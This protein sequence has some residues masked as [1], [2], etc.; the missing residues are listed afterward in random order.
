MRV[1]C[2]YL[3]HSD[4]DIVQSVTHCHPPGHGVRRAYSLL[5]EGKENASPNLVFSPKQI[6]LFA[7][8]IV[9][10]ASW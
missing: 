2:G 4:I 5:P 7:G 9:L 8:G 6:L 1:L 10:S 3:G